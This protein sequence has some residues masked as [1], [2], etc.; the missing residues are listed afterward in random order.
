MSP[1][2]EFMHSLHDMSIESHIIPLQNEEKLDSLKSPPFIR[3]LLPELIIS[4]IQVDPVVELICVEGETA[5]RPMTQDQYEKLPR[6]CLYTRKQAFLL[7]LGFPSNSGNT[8]QIQGIVLDVC[9]PLERYLEHSLANDI[10]R[11]RPAPQR[12]AGFAMVC[13]P[14]SLAA[15]VCNRDINEYSLLMHH[16]TGKVTNTL[17]FRME[18]IQDP[19]QEDIVDFVFAQSRGLSLLSALTIVMLKGSGDLLSASPLAFDG[20]TVSFMALNETLDYLGEMVDSL[21]RSTAMWRKYRAAQVYILQTFANRGQ[22]PFIKAKVLGHD[23]PRHPT[24]WDVLVQGP[25]LFSTSTDPSRPA[26][27]LENC[28]SHDDLV[29]IAIGRV[30]YSVDFAA[31]APTCFVPRFQF[32]QLTRLQDTWELNDAASNMGAWCEK[33]SLASDS[34]ESFEQS[35]TLL[36]DPLVDSIIHLAT[37]RFVF[38]IHTNAIRLVINKAGQAPRTTAWLGLHTP[39]DTSLLTG[40]VV[41]AGSDLEHNLLIKRSNG[42]TEAI[43]ITELQVKEEFAAHFGKKEGEKAPLEAI[44]IPFSAP[45]LYDVLDGHVKNV[46]NG[47]ASLAK[48]V[49]SDT[50]YKDITPDILAVVIHTKEQCDGKLILPLLEMKKIVTTRQQLLRRVIEDQKNQIQKLKEVE[51]ALRQQQHRLSS[52]IDIME[53]NAQQLVERSNHAREACTVFFP[54]ATA[55]EYAFFKHIDRLKEKCTLLETLF[56]KLKPRVQ[57]QVDAFSSNDLPEA[58]QSFDEILGSKANTLLKHQE[59]KITNIRERLKAASAQL[60]SLAGECT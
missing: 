1:D 52:K 31:I 16:G 24:S 51:V 2:G 34:S 55:A 13:P 26:K 56:Q 57:S 41:P 6:L 32:E 17:I 35:M 15:L 47:L 44:D 42:S 59:I 19:I 18:E 8:S 40:M 53:S 12:H 10:I 29:G 21:D 4:S 39:S 48:L 20:C 25:I 3:T 58:I 28:S 46:M 54:K 22:S 38:T 14:G 43:N 36:H 49:G 45:P 30:G 27:V 33:V 11:I 60:E 50:N 7:Q 23:D 37:P 9:Q 5:K